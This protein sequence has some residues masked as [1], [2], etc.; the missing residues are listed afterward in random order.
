M[1]PSARET[2]RQDQADLRSYAERGDRE[3]LA[4]LFGRAAPKLKRLAMQ[5][6]RDP[7]AA[8]DIVQVTYLA[9]MQS[10]A[11][12]DRRR[13]VLPWL[14]GIL[15]HRAT[16]FYR[17]AERA[18]RIYDPHPF[19]EP[20]VEADPADHAAAEETIDTVTQAILSMPAP[21]RQLLTRRLI[22]GHRAADI[23]RTNGSSSDTVRSQL[24]RGLAA[25]REQ[26]A[27]ESLIA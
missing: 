8:A 13:P 7:D 10:I 22:H 20:T 17:N 6:T 24:S 12:F 25:L 15:A 9:A 16:D 26:V 5:L 11:A 14:R 21:Y 27:L 1:T 18:G 4:R 19:V 2:A 3:A 23:A